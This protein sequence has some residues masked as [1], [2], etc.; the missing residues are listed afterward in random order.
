MHCHLVTCAGIFSAPVKAH[1]VLKGPGGLSARLLR[2]PYAWGAAAQARKVLG[3]ESNS[4]EWQMRSGDMTSI[5]RDITVQA[6]SLAIDMRCA[7]TGGNQRSCAA[8]SA[9]SSDPASQFLCCL[10]DMGAPSVGRGAN[11]V[12]V[13]CMSALVLANLL[14]LFSTAGGSRCFGGRTCSA[15]LAR[16]TNSVPQCMHWRC[17]GFQIK[18][19]SRANPKS[20]AWAAS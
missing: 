3:L 6:R 11:V 7:S 5:E 14:A 12:R 4:P 13:L 16:N 18:R 1:D 15:R 8:L 9:A 2:G 20:G 19:F 10:G 17:R